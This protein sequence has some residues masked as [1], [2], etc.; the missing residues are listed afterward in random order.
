MQSENPVQFAFEGRAYH[1]T[2]DDVLVY[3]QAYAATLSAWDSGA[4][5]SDAPAYTVVDLGG[6]TMAAFSIVGCNPVRD[7]LYSFEMGMIY[8]YS[9]IS[10]DIRSETGKRVEE[11]QIQRYL[12]AARCFFRR[13][14][15]TMVDRFLYELFSA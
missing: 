13:N 4:L 3:P 10:R 6:W 11:L 2:V 1:V 9:Q 7:S 8:L 14:R 15:G 12:E 5:P